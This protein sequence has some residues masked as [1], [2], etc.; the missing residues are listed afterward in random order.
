LRER[1]LLGEHVSDPKE[2]SPFDRRAGDAADRLARRLERVALHGL[3]R[4]VPLLQLSTE[5]ALGE[6]ER[7]LE[8]RLLTLSRVG[9]EK[10]EQ[11][12]EKWPT[13]LPWECDVY[14]VIKTSG[15]LVG[16]EVESRELGERQAVARI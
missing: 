1:D 15:E 6:D 12:T 3:G 9:R 2:Q 10:A 16:E 4:L 7:S 8:A 11:L 5:A 13:V 14:W